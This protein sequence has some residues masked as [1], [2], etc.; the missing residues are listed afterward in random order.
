METAPKVGVDACFYHSD[1]LQVR[2]DFFDR[3]NCK[4]AHEWELAAHMYA[5]FRI[6]A[7]LKDG[8]KVTPDKV[9]N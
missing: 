9:V 1:F 6:C 4:F 3:R 7:Y 2:V 8:G 5:C